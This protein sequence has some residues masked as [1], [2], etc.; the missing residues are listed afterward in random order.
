MMEVGNSFAF[1]RRDVRRRTQQARH[2]TPAAVNDT[3]TDGSSD[4]RATQPRSVLVLPFS[5]GVR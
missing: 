5:G 3:A 2:R 1:Q 4:T